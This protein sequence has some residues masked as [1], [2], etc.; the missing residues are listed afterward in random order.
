[1][2]VT[3]QDQNTGPLRVR[4]VILDQSPIQDAFY[5][6]TDKDIV[7]REFVITVLGYPNR[8]GLHE[9]NNSVAIA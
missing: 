2:P 4:R 8:A 6:I 3:L 5:D 1:M 7:R 9:S